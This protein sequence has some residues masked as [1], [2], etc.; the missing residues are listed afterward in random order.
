MNASTKVYVSNSK[1]DSTPYLS[2]F[3]PTYNDSTDLS[4]CLKS[5]SHLDYP[6]RKLEI[7]IW[8]NA[9]NDDTVDMVRKT[10]E[11]MKKEG[12]LNLL[13]IEWDRNEGTYI[14]YNLA[15]R[16]ISAQ[17][18][19]IL[20]LDADVELAPNTLTNLVA[21]AAGDRV[22]V[23]GARSVYF[24]K[25]DLTSFGAGFVSGWTAR[26]GEEDA[27]KKTECDYV[28]GCCWLLD[29]EIFERLECL[30]PDYYLLHWEVDYCLR[31]KNNG[32]RVIYEPK[33]VAKHN[34]P[35]KGTRNPERLYYLYRNK[36]LLIRKIPT[37]FKSPWTF[38]FC[39][40]FSLAR[41]LIVLPWSLKWAE[42]RGGLEGLYDGLLDKR[43]KKENLL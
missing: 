35:L 18:E 1:E 33:A 31:V 10:Y 19:Y 9:S 34:I 25:P 20:G 2:I 42:I 27:Q 38:F 13:L 39:S 7:I 40:G 5:L 11:E 12:W 3:I 22:A 6:K 36:F 41:L 15:L 30:D 4:T 29:R 17:A 24:S 16:H 43:G 21:A 23:V 37:F 32:F 26:Y 8:D 14:P 28:I